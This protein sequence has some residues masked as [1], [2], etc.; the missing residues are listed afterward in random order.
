MFNYFPL[1]AI[2]TLV[3]GGNSVTHL[4]V[5]EL[6]LLLELGRHRAHESLGTT[7][8]AH[9]T[10]LRT[11]KGLLELTTQVRRLLGLLLHIGL[12]WALHKW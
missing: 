5:G 8:S 10:L 11:H 2:A 4:L 3:R 7:H 9:H 12:L 1:V 6:L